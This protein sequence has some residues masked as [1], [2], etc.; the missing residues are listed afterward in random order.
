[1][2]ALASLAQGVFFHFNDTQQITGYTIFLVTLIIIYLI[3]VS[4]NKNSNPL[5]EKIY[6]LRIVQSFFV[7][8]TLG[9]LGNMTVPFRNNNQLR[10]ALIIALS[11]FL[12]ALMQIIINK[13]K[14]KK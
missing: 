3:Q 6:R 4:I 2:F 14:F 11:L 1:M 9:G 12:V 7:L 10:N 13:I 5:N 8:T